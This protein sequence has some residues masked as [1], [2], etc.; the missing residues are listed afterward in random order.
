MFK[1]TAIV[2]HNRIPQLLKGTITTTSHETATMIKRPG[3]NTV[4]GIL[5]YLAKDEIFDIEKPYY[6]YY[7]YDF[8]L[9]RTN[10]KEQYATVEVYN[11]RDLDESAESMFLKRGFAKINVASDLTALEHYEPQKVAADL[12]PQYEVLARRLFPTAVRFQVLEHTV[13]PESNDLR[14]S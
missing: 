10:T 13:C 9:P 3:R 4:S 8:D 12:Y 11:A 5:Q 2:Q 6:L 14:R 1:F 7:N